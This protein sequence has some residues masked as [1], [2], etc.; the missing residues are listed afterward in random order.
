MKLGLI[1]L[2][3]FKNSLILCGTGA[4]YYIENNKERIWPIFIANYFFLN[5]T[6]LSII[7]I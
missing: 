1:I 4:I 3:Q 2:Y 6:T 5:F 7:R